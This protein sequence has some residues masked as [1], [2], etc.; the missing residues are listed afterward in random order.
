MYETTP[1]WYQQLFEELGTKYLD[2]PVTQ[3]TIQELDFIVALL[4]LPKGSKI[5]DV[6]CGAGRHSIA[7]AK[8]GCQVTGLDY[9]HR[10]IELASEK[11]KRDGVMVEFVYGD[12]PT[13]ILQPKSLFFWQEI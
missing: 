11:A 10:M 12:A 2:F 3:G 5:L 8:R 9:S 1:D 4:E 6:G 13:I 7:L